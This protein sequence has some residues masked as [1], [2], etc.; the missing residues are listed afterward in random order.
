MSDKRKK[1]IKEICEERNLE[2]DDVNIA[3]FE[4]DKAHLVPLSGTTRYTLFLPKKFAE[5]DLSAMT[6]KIAT[7]GFNY[8]RASIGSI[9]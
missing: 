9:S 3:K 4:C 2:I 1:V 7:M 5:M 8:V 6:E